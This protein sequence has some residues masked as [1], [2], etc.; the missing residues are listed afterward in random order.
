MNLISFKIVAYITILLWLTGCF[1]LLFNHKIKNGNQIG[2]II[3]FSGILFIIAFVVFLWINL[4]RPPLRTIGETRLWYSVLLPLIGFFIF[5]KWNYKWLLYYSISIAIIFL[6][7]NLANPQNFDKNLMPALQSI[8]FVP[9]VIAYMIAYALLGVCMAIAIWG[10]YLHKFKSFKY[11]LLNKADNLVLMGF[12]FL[13]IGLLLGA[14]WA[15]IAWGH[16]WSWDPKETWALLTWLNFIFYLHF[17]FYHKQK[18]VIPL[19]TL[20]VGFILLMFCWIGINYLPVSKNSIH[21][22]SF[23]LIF[24]YLNSIKTKEKP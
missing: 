14:L 10:L 5:T 16:Y 18:I 19:W 8:W 4:E 12:S 7:I 2:K 22:Y 1:F 17:R 24:T 20:I 3:T 9:H 23:I 13:T 11:E 21:T 6:I 15:K